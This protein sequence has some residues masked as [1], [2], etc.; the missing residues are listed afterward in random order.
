MKQTKTRKILA[1]LFI[2]CG[3]LLIVIGSAMS[4]SESTGYNLKNAFTGLGFI[5][6]GAYILFLPSKPQKK[7]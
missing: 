4:S 3:V 7:K 1:T 2:V 6:F 5:A